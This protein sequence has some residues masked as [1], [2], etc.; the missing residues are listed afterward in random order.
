[1]NAALM[2]TC[3][4]SST[5][6]LDSKP[7]IVA[8]PAS[9]RRFEP[10]GNEGPRSWVR[11]KDHPAYRDAIASTSLVTRLRSLAVFAKNFSIVVFKRFISYE[12]IPADIRLDGGIAFARAALSNIVAK[13]TAPAQINTGSHG[14]LVAD[15]LTRDGICVVAIELSQLARIDAAAQPSLDQLRRTRGYRKAGGRDFME[16]RGCALRQENEE[17]FA[18]VETMLRRTGVLAGVSRYLGGRLFSLT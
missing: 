17:L 16:S 6:E 2:N 4:G 11:Y 5:P 18:A 12:L 10:R 15:T 8:P 1:M 14:Q 9:M 13:L 7:L 3:A